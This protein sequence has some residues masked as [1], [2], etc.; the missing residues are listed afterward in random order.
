MQVSVSIVSFNTKDLLK[1]CISSLLVQKTQHK[2]DILVLDNN[3]SDESPKM[4]KENFSDKIQLIGNSENS[5]FAKGQN[6]ILKQIK[7][8]YVL[9]LNPDTQ[10]QNDAIEKMVSFM[11]ENPDCGI[12]SCKLIGSGGETQS[13]GGDFP[14]YIALFSWLFNLEIFGVKSNFHRTEKNFYDKVKEVDWVGGTFMMVR[15]DVFE[16][17]GYFD[18]D[19][20]MYFEDTEFCFRA[21]KKGFKVMI[22]PSVTVSHQSGASSKNP[23][24]NQ[25]KGEFRGVTH[26]YKKELGSFAS[27]GLKLMIYCAVLLR[28]ITFTLLGKVDIA[29]TYTK[30]LG[31]I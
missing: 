16:K 28:I 1:Q 4:L 20:F 30:V 14:F 7:G 18:E 24:F 9:I 25:W 19:Y 21:R 17:V 29:K 27:F 10:M 6:K 12:S 15:K 22:N 5:G 23:R 13:N 31:E 3:S 11:E 8:D 26:F 2:L